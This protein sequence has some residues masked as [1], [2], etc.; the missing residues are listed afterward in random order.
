MLG[1]HVRAKLSVSVD[2]QTLPF[3]FP[4][5]IALQASHIFEWAKRYYLS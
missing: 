4:S 5:G 1:G 2:G 3:F